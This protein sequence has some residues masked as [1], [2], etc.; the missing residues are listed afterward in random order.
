VLDLYNTANDKQDLCENK[1]LYI[2]SLNDHLCLL[3]FQIKDIYKTI[4][5]LSDS[6][7]K[8]EVEK[9]KTAEEKALSCS[10]KRK[11]KNA[12]PSFAFSE[13]IEISKVT[14]ATTE[15]LVVEDV[16]VNVQH[17][18]EKNSDDN[19]QVEVIHLDDDKTQSN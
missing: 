5:S 2:E 12:I 14:T 9:E 7:E 10:K 11:L 18:K 16:L 19:D 1:K 4:E 3:N 8:K 6:I 17:S 15:T 13:E